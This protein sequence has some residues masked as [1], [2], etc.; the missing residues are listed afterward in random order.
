MHI[1]AIDPGT[2]ESGFCYLDAAD[3]RPKRHGKAEN[4]S[5]IGM[6]RSA[7]YGEA[8]VIERLASY[9]MP[10]G[11]EVLETCEWVGRFTEAACRAGKTVY[12]VYRKDEKL[13][14]C[15][16]PKANDATIRRALIDRFAQ[17]DLKSGKGTKANP[18]W[19]Y[20]FAKDAWQAY[21]VA[22]T[23]ADKYRRDQEDAE[24]DRAQL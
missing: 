22:V 2:T 17:R 12:Y 8:V 19:F 24:K 13:E 4:E 5:V 21:A 16:S 11:K 3:M 6:A 7:E 20:G 10:V 9:G 14:I 1:L 18:D 15:Q 23:W